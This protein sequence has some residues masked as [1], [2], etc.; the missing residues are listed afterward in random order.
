MTTRA[1][2]AA[3]QPREVR[4]VLAASWWL[5]RRPSLVVPVAA[6]AVLVAATA[7]VLD[8]G[9][10]LQVLRGVTLLL[11]CA[12]AAATDDP[13]GEVLAASPYPRSVRSNARLLA[14]I[15]LV[16]PAWGVAAL[17]VEVRA[18]AVPVLGVGVE[19][20]AL[21]AAAV[22]VGFGL[23]AWRDQHAPSF[24]ATLALVGLAFATGVAPRWY[25]LQ[26]SQTWGPPW[27]AAQFRWAGLVLVM[28]GVASL[29]LRDPL[30]G[31]P[32]AAGSPPAEADPLV[33]SP[34][35]VVRS[36]RRRH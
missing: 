33:G 19:A 4:A 15:A 34:V 2:E 24:P 29:A 6:A 30:A 32:G 23:R 13:S 26:Q 11:A 27:Q 5:V 20:L 36:R 8:D 35:A 17:V 7:P 21:G 3:S 1:S 22:A 18:P 16:G 14:A 31:R 25:A 9:Y 10:G 12:L 28:L